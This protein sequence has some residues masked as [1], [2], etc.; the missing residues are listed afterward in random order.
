MRRLILAPFLLILF[1]C[2]DSHPIQPDDLLLGISEEPTLAVSQDPGA[3]PKWEF[4]STQTFVGPVEEGDV[5]INPAGMMFGD[6]LINEFAVTGTLGGEPLEGLSYFIGDYRLNQNDGKARARSR[7]GLWVITESALGVG[8]FECVMTTKIE[9][10]F[11]GIVQYGN[12]TG[13]HGTGDFEGMRMK[14]YTTNEANPG[15]PIYATWGEIW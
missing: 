15:I 3:N 11:S 8:T 13:C 1:A 4:T 14:A 2:G 9:D 7:P 6:G 5:R 12:I 10:F